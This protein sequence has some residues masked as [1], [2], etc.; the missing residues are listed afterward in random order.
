MKPVPDHIGPYRILQ[1]LGLGG[2]GVVYRGVHRATGQPAAVKTVRLTHEGQLAGLRREI[3]ALARLRHPGIARILG[4]GVEDGL[5][6]VALELVEGQTLRAYA[7]V[8]GAGSRPTAKDSRSRLT[9]GWSAALEAET[10]ERLEEAGGEPVEPASPSAAGRRPSAGL[11]R[12]TEVLT[13]IRRLCDALSFLHGEGLVHRDLK[14]ENVLV[15]PDGRPVIVDFGLA[16]SLAPAGRESLESHAWS[17]GTAAYV[18]PEQVRAELVDARAD[19]Y[20]LG[21]ILYELLTGRVP[22]LANNAETVLRQHLAAEPIPPSALVEG[23][24][25]QLEALVLGLLAK[26]PRDRLGHADDVAAVLAGLG[27]EATAEPGPRPRAYL[28]RPGFSGRFEVLQRIQRLCGELARGSGRLVLVP[29]ESGAGKTR[30]A[31][32]AAREARRRRLL[33]LA[34]ECLPGQAG[35]AEPLQALRKPLQSVADRCREL[36]PE[37]SRRVFGPRAAILSPY[38]RALEALPGLGELPEPPELTPEAAQ[39]RLFD[40]L[41]G[42]F[43]AVAVEQPLLLLLDDLQW[44]DGLTLGFLRFLVQTERLERGAWLVLGTV[45]SEEVGGRASLRALLADPRVEALALDRLDEAAVGA[46]VAEMLAL[47]RPPERFVRFMAGSSEGIPFFVAE[48][49]RLAVA[50]GVLFRDGL[51]RWKISDGGS[52]LAATPGAGQPA[53][54]PYEALPLPG[55]VRQLVERRLDGLGEAA[56]RAVEAA[57]VLGREADEAVLAEAAGLAAEALWSGVEE[58]IVRQVLEEAPGGRLRFGHDKLREVAY[59]RIDQAQRRRLHEAAAGALESRAST[60]GPELYAVLA[61]HWERAGA[62]GLARS[63]YLAAARRAADRYAH[64]EA[65]RLYRS[66][67]RLAP[68]RGEERIV[69]RNELGG[70][71]LRLRGRA[72]EAAAQHE[73]ALAEARQLGSAGLEA[74]SLWQLSQALQSVGR[75]EEAGPLIERVVDLERGLGDRA[76]EATALGGLASVRFSQGRLQEAAE[77]LERALQ[78]FRQVGD[79]RGTGAMLLRKAGLLHHLARLEEGQALCEQALAVY[80]E[81]GDPHMEGKILADLGVCHMSQGRALEAAD[82]LEQ[83]LELFRQVGDRRSEATAS[84][85]LA[86]TRVHARQFEEARRLLEETMQIQREI[87][88]RVGHG[89]TAANLAHVCLEQAQLVEARGWAERALQL[90]REAGARF[91]EGFALSVLASVCKAEGRLEQALQLARQALEVHQQTGHRQG[92]E[93][94]RRLLE[95]FEAA[96]QS[97]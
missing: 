20:A 1:P 37:E 18:A 28:Y 76:A 16:A 60:A 41:A 15:R 49:L 46:M 84:M 71:V 62:S 64:D 44:A 92:E 81:L 42:A 10:L 78:L 66:A 83:S 50:E 34:G 33:V 70:R 25:D 67:L 57:S 91:V 82:L 4:D 31:L 6:W 5:P 17:G 77:S 75:P 45:R 3:H 55:T 39:Q 69:L 27:A 58:L 7:G 29:G 48:Y 54:L 63:L 94:V 80:R 21:C 8:S 32:E 13:V 90:L 93:M 86:Y 14:P 87:A 65:E 97:G 38:E 43:A 26:E 53:T 12:L 51:G 35:S 9:S 85:N 59:E 24:P 11:G 73:A 74:D 30:L 96:T 36:G 72:A 47:D 56:R 2:M 89:V 19:L 40:A 22:F 68:E 61:E 95:E 79:P 88:D 23:V 52:S